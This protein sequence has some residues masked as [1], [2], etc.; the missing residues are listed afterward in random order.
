MQFW[1]HTRC[2]VQRFV[3]HYLLGWGSIQADVHYKKAG[4][5]INI[6]GVGCLSGLRHYGLKMRYY[7]LVWGCFDVGA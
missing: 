2:E 3:K 7:V 5:L 6:R 1:H 4:F